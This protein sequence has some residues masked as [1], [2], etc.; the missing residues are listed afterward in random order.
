MKRMLKKIFPPPVDA[1]NREIE[2]VLSAIRSN[3]AADELAFTRFE[4]ELMK[5]KE[6]NMRL[7][8]M[9]QT[10]EKQIDAVA[11]VMGKKLEAA[12][13]LAKELKE[14][15][16]EVLWGEIFR[17]T[18]AG[19]NWL[20]D[21]SFS[22]GR[23]AAGYP[24]LYALYRT[25]DEQKPKRILELG[26]GQT[27]R[28]IAQYAAA[29]EDVQHIVVEHDSAWISFF[30]KSFALS[31]RSRI[32]TLSLE[33]HAYLEDDAV[34]SYGSFSDALQG[35]RFDLLS[36]DGPFGGN[37]NLYARVDV[38]RMLPDCLADSFAIL[39]DDCDRS[40]ER[41]TLAQM[42]Q[43]LKEC[44]IAYRIGRYAGQKETRVIVSE[45]WRFLCSM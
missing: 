20:T 6:E 40:G 35:Q 41:R 14:T 28:M 16:E 32:L 42:E 25:L 45:D 21:R 22:P 36:I 4:T 37:A 11:S 38:L 34:L 33:E 1:F 7:A 13:L 27:T 23:W 39:L 29:H 43:K 44:G 17:D 26:L 19:S 18:I 15:Q 24:F 2:R 12:S 8:Q 9:L 10:R 3:H 31:D 30:Q 5:L